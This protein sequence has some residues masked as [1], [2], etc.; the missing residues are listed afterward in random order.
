MPIYCATKAALHSLTLSLR[1]QLRQTA[2]QVFEVAPPSVDTE[3]GHDRRVDKNESHGGIPVS[4]FIEEAMQALENDILE[5]PIAG[6]K[7]L[8]EK[9]EGL[10]NLMNQ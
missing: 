7:R 10:F 6:A 8:H 9:R 5:A 1:H 4:E 2:V 3:L